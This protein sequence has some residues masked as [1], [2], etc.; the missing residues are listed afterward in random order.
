MLIAIHLVI[1]ALFVA[2]GIVFL[3]GKGAFLIAG[4]NTAPE[5]EKA[6]IDARKLCAL[7]GR[8]MLVLAVCWIPV[9]I[10]TATGLMWIFWL[11]M[12]LFLAATVCGVILINTGDRIRK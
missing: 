10:G 3:R 6:K 9:T 2:L 5:E 7:T 4:Y 8:L 1:I 12:A 11:G